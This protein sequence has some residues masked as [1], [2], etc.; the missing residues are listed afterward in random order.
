MK[1]LKIECEGLTASFRFPHFMQG[2]Q[3]TFEMPPPAT[4]YGLICSAVGEWVSPEDLGFGYSFRFMA[5]VDD[6]E[7]LHIVEHS[8]GRLPETQLPKNLE[9]AV[10]PTKRELL[11]NPMLTLYI[12]KPDWMEKFKSPRYAVCLGRSQDLI[13]IRKVEVVDLQ[14]SQEVYFEHT[15][16]P[17][18]MFLGANSG[19]VILLPKF[20][21]VSANRAPI[22]EHYLILHSRLL[23]TDDRFRRAVKARR[24]FWADLTEHSLGS[25]TRGVHMHSFV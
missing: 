1:T 8:S 9:G 17:K 13:T 4:V 14:E 18:E 11:F 2:R 12:N 24:P 3:P 22:F 16:L 20:L 15:L 10:N 7:A 25:L 21:D 5:K 6:L 23:T 19:Y